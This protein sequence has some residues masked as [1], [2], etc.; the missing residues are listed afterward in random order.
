M[1]FLPG[2][3]YAH[4]SKASWT[5]PSYLFA[6]VWT[7]LYVVMAVAAWLV[8]LQGGFRRNSLALG[9]FVVQLALNAAWSFICFGLHELT[10][11]VADMV[12]LWVLVLLTTAAFYRVNRLAG[13]LMVP[14]L[15]WVA[16]AAS[17]NVALWRL[18]R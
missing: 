6:P 16:F 3:W 11:S 8:W 13:W 12:S 14:Y 18:N 4:L 5:P 9:L 7:V 17:L 1:V 10:F 15:L 2:R